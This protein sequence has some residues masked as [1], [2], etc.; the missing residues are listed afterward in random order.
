MKNAPKERGKVIP[1]HPAKRA[2]EQKWGRDVMKFGFCIVPSLLLRAQERL[3]LNATQ[4]A[5][6]MHLATSGGR[7]RASRTRARRRSASV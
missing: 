2:S 4:L 5:I 1:L 7:R 3:K 6:L